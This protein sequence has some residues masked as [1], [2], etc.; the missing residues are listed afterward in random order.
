MREAIG[1]GDTIGDGNMN[2]VGDVPGVGDPADPVGDG[3]LGAGIAGDGSGCVCSG[4]GEARM[5]PPPHPASVM[6]TVIATAGRCNLGTNVIVL[7]S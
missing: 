4:G 3:M 1:V 2:G 5:A 7:P 6:R